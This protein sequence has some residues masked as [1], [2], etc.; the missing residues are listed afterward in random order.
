M[1]AAMGN[2]QAGALSIQMD[3]PGCKPVMHMD[4]CDENDSKAHHATAGQVQKRHHEQAAGCDTL[5]C[6]TPTQQAAGLI[7]RAL[8]NP[9]RTASRPL[10]YSLESPP[11]QSQTMAGLLPE[12]TGPPVPLYTKFCVLRY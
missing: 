8:D 11:S 7:D 6:L 5:L 10:H 4:S 1:L 12:K 3:C 9:D 2:I